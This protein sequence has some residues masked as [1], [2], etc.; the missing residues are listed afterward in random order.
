MCG[1][2]IAVLASGNGSNFE[3]LA[4]ACADGRIPAEV[5]LLVCDRPGAYVIERAAKYGIDTLVFNPKDYPSKAVY[6]KEIADRLDA[7]GV[8]L[9]C[10][11]G[12]MRIISPELLGRYGGRIINIHPSLLP[13][14]KGAHAIRDAFDSGA[15]VYGVT[16]HWVDDTLDGGEIIAQRAFHYEGGSMAEV[17]EKIHALEHELYVDTVNEILKFKDLRI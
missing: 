13:A 2:K 6:E 1:K 12:Y 8:N 7:K 3:A 4:A 16:I 9:V 17:E 15:R 11:A 5:A 10:L 14:F